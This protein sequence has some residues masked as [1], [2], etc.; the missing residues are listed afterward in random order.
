MSIFPLIDNA[1]IRSIFDMTKHFTNNFQKSFI[2][3]K[4]NG[5]RLPPSSLDLISMKLK[6][7][8]PR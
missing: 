3:L 6:R 4:I 8:G 2:S 7:G 5:I 1:N